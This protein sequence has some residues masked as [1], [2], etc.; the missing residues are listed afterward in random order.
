V[1]AFRIALMCVFVALPRGISAQT[2][3][4]LIP[5]QNARPLKL[6][7]VV[8]EHR[9]ENQAGQN[10]L[11]LPRAVPQFVGM[12]GGHLHLLSSN[13]NFGAR[14][15]SPESFTF[16]QHSDG[17]VYF[18]TSVW[19]QAGSR[20]ISARA[21]VLSPTKIEIRLEH[22]ASD[23]SE[24]RTVVQKESIMLKNPRVMDCIES[25]QVFSQTNL[26]TMSGYEQPIFSAIYHG[27]LQ[28]MTDPEIEALK[29]E[30]IR[31]GAVPQ[32]G[33]EGSGKFAP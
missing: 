29:D 5:R 11:E 33:V 12:W 19:G 3:Q 20:I 10:E 8:P 31:R 6:P 22:L 28:Q 9:P 1:K 2:L 16:G 24:T 15:S 4:P 25:D 7:P 26:D 21:K 17:T 32:I 13:V 30:L 14:E 23:G 27:S 18:E